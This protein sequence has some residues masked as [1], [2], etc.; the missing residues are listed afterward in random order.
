MWLEKYFN[1]IIIGSALF[2][3][4]LLWLAENQ[5]LAGASG[6]VLYRAIHYP[7]E[8][9][10]FL[11]PHSVEYAIL[12]M[13]GLSAFSLWLFSRISLLLGL[14]KGTTFALFL[15]LNFNPEYNDTRLN[16]EVFQFCLPLYLSSIYLFL[17]QKYF[18]QALFLWAIPLWLSAL[19]SPL[20]LFWNLLFPVFLLFYPVGKWQKRTISLMVYYLL[21]GLIIYLVAPFKEALYD[22]ILQSVE[23]LSR[24]SFEMSLFFSEESSVELSIA[25]GFLLSGVLVGTKILQVSGL[26][27]GGVIFIAL[28]KRFGSVFSG[29]II[30]FFIGSL[31]L[32]MML[33]TFL[34]LYTGYLFNDLVYLPIIMMFLWLSSPAVFYL[35]NK[36]VQPQHFLVGIWLLV[37][38]ALA[39]II[40]FGPSKLYLKEAGEWASR[41]PAREIHSNSREALFYAGIDPNK[42]LFNIHFL[43]DY[44]WTSAD[45]ILYSHRRK[46]PLPDAMELY[47]VIKEFQNERGDKVFLLRLKDAKNNG[48]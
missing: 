45:L 18:P 33:A 1:S 29:K 8:L 26:L 10:L 7:N 36:E 4:L 31:F 15:L 43:P 17:K 20:F 16:I 38:Y 13:N 42:P 47:D 25:D 41:L 37:G 19:L 24:S 39:S 32:K 34:L 48:L 23:K 14:G 22:V 27:I 40:V 21:A 9:W 46:T 30:Y 6:Q 3:G 35:L 12:L 5:V 28:I 44:E 11:I 2:T